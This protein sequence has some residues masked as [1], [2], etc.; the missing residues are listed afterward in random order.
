MGGHCCCLGGTFRVFGGVRF[1]LRVHDARV[2]I[3]NEMEIPI[4]ELNKKKEVLIATF[5]Q[6]LKK[7]KN[8]MIS[9]C[10]EED[11]YKSI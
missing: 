8:S 3:S 7:K 6:H 4:P 9:G 1:V 10:G 5:K 11:V 2:R